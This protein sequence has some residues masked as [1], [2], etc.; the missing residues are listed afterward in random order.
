MSVQVA[1]MTRTAASTG[2]QLIYA[3]R[4]VVYGIYPELTTTG[5]LTFRDGAAADA[6]GTIFH[7]CAIGLL[8]AG[9]MFGD[10]YAPRIQK[11]LTIQQSVSTDQCLVVWAPLP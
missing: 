2:E 1:N 5:T 3:G 11:G 9:K 4:C 7:V 6:S 8:Q 10:A